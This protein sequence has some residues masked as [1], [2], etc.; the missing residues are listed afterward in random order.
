MH[1][2]GVGVFIA[3]VVGDGH[4]RCDYAEGTGGEGHLEGGAAGIGRHCAHWRP[5]NAESAGIGATE[6]HQRRAG[7][8]EGRR[9]AVAH[10][11]GRDHLAAD[12]NTAQVGAIGRAGGGVAVGNAD[13]VA[14]EIDFGR[15]ANALND[16]GVAIFRVIS[17][18]NGYR[19]RDHAR[20]FRQKIELEGYA[21]VG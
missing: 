19:S 5:R 1:H 11:K 3:I 13:A 9:P 14:L 4:G 20:R 10:R 7:Q 17:V 6:R 16:K 8:T 2:K 21:T 12:H 15:Q 18:G